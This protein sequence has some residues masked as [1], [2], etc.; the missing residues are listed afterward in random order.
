MRTS[1][2]TAALLLV[3]AATAVAQRERD[4]FFGRRVSWYPSLES[5]LT[6]GDGL[7]ELERRRMRFFGENPTEKKHVLVYVRPVNEEKEPGDFQNADVI[8]QSRQAWAFVKMDFDKENKWLKAWSVSRAPAVVATDLHGN[9][10][11]KAA[12]TDAVRNLLK[13]IPELITAYE[14]KIKADWSKVCD[15]LKLEDER[16]A[17]ALVDFCKAAKPGYKET[18]EAHAKLTEVSESALKRGELAESVSVDAGAVYYD[19]LSRTYGSTAPGVLAQIRLAFLEHERGNVRK[20]LDSLVRLQK[21]ERLSPH[22]T[23]E[24]AKTLQEISK[25]GDAKIEAALAAPDKTAAREVLRRL[26][27]EYAGTEAGRRAADVAR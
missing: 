6:G 7:N 19:D 17:K 15:Q 12:S 13:G 10:F 21:Q 5:A 1:I 22:E 16:V 18:Q 11:G 24:I 20:A 9:A 8:A 14:A 25:R 23:E 27:S 3:S 2:A 4:D 26:A